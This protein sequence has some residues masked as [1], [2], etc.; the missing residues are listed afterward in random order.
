MDFRALAERARQG[1]K[2]NTVITGKDLFTRYQRSGRLGLVWITADLGHNIT[3]KLRVECAEFKIPLIV[4]GDSVM[5]NEVIG[6]D[7]T[8]VF[9][10]KKA[11]PGL[12]VIVREYAEAL[13]PGD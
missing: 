2:R 1:M 5:V 3:C 11:H 8:K 12:P 7:C 10:F 6:R 9:L 13:D 4:G